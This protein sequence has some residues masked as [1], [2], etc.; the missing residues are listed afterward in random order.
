MTITGMASFL[1]TRVSFP[2]KI[3]FVLH[4][5]DHAS[6]E[7]LSGT[8]LTPEG[9]D[10]LLSK[11]IILKESSLGRGTGGTLAGFY[12]ALSLLNNRTY[13]SYH[14]SMNLRMYNKCGYDTAAHE[15]RH[16]ASFWSNEMYHNLTSE[17]ATSLTAREMHLG[18]GIG[19]L[20]NYLAMYPLQFAIGNLV[21]SGLVFGY[22]MWDM[23][24]EKKKPKTSFKKSNMFQEEERA[25]AFAAHFNPDIYLGKYDL[26]DIDNTIDQKRAAIDND[27]YFSNLAI[28]MGEYPNQKQCADIHNQAVDHYK[29]NGSTLFPQGIKSMDEA[30]QAY[31]AY[32][33]SL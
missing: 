15:L 4:V 26:D 19:T 29:Q 2:E 28:S 32:S 13:L 8:N 10:K 3:G 25:N 21:L 30:F 22:T 17:I 9:R 14:P 27:Y 1:D 16:A 20:Q 23:Q 33:L 31:K 6:D 7:Q 12:P 18:I 5:L 24:Q 11:Q